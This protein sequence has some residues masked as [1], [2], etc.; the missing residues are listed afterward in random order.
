[1]LKP[2]FVSQM[3]EAMAD[4]YGAVTDRILINLAK[5]FSFL[6][7]GVEMPG[8]FDYQA[9]MLA[10]MGQ[11]NKE[12][13]DIIMSGL[14]GADQALRQAL[15]ASII[16]ALEAEEPKLRKA[17]EKGILQPPSIPE[18]VPGQ[19]QAFQAYYKQSADKLNLVNTVML[20]ST[21]AAYA[22]T[23]SDIAN[24]IARTQTI[25]NVGAGEVVTGVTAYNQAVRESVRKMVSNGITGFVDHGGHH[26]TPEAYAAMDIR[27]TMNNVARAATWERNEGYGND[28][29]QVSWH[30]GARPLCYPWQGKVIS[31]SD[32]SREVEDLD[33][34]SVHVYAQ[35][36]TSYGEEAGLFGINCGHYPMVF[37]PGVSTLYDVPQDEEENKKD[38]EESQ[39]QRALERKLRYEKRDLEVLK[40]QGASEDLLKAQQAKVKK[41][42]HDID[43]F[44]EETG[45]TRRRDRETTPIN[46]K[47]PPK[48]SYDSKLFPTKER[49]KMRDWYKNG[50]M[51]DNPP[52]QPAN[53]HLGP[54]NI[55]PQ[56]QAQ[57]PVAQK[58][59]E[60]GFVPANTVSEAEEYAKKFLDNPKYGNVSYKGIDVEYANTCNRVLTEVF[61]EYTPQYRLKAIEPMN[62]RKAAFKQ[63][64][65]SSEAC[66][67]WGGDGSLFVNPNFYKNKKAFEKHKAQ[68]DQ[69]MSY[70]LDNSEI[71]LKNATGAKK[72]Y[73]EALTKTRRQCVSQSHNFVEGTFVHE[74]GHMLDDKL[75]RKTMKEINSPLATRGAITD[76]VLKYGKGISGYAVSSANEY[77]A[78]SFTAWWY[79]ETSIV[80]PELVRVFEEAKKYGK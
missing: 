42:S 61:D 27:T 62:G 21:Q 33:G 29:Y 70:V 54:D 32:L 2:A 28:L 66:Y 10:Q 50:G 77:I 41:A 68:I 47:F 35:S 13:I 39:Q 37:V 51:D 5:Y 53:I 17:A 71:L 18:V 58:P 30:N 9:R 63:A 11:I 36:E 15:E 12:T 57:I 56:A 44:C 45:R 24:K 72:D 73:I 79:G 75:F 48:G 64:I 46:A 23:V 20:E 22:A 4:V 65:E 38:Y 60:S 34:N 80:D 40:A 1:M 74:C 8:S 69:L 19:M 59:P 14:D 43:D 7:A 16:H 67:Q 52:P 26:W 49:D 31:R 76:S 55:P 78:E 3:S 6:K 25:L